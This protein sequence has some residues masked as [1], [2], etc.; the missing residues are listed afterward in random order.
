MLAH[1]TGNV[2][3]TQDAALTIQVGGF[4]LAVSVFDGLTFTI[5]QTV[6]LYTYVHW[7]QDQAPSLFGFRTET[8]KT[9]FCLLL[10]CSGVGPKLA[11]A[12]LNKLGVDQI[13]HAI[14]TEDA[15]ILSNAPGVG[16]KKAEQMILHLKHKIDKLSLII[17]T[18]TLES[19]LPLHDV[20]QALNALNYSKG[21][22]SYAMNQLKNEYQDVRPSFDQ[23]LRKALSFLAK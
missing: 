22:I 8:E 12:V 9:V 4:G 6:T 1:V 16:I 21:E 14:Q 3:A 10:E 13:V 15:R 17:A 23:L 20:I 2:V 19:P 11:L 18:A 7:Q 5:G